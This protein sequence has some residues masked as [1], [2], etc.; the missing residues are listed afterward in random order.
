[1]ATN[2][3]AQ[4][5][6]KGPLSSALGQW[7]ALGIGSYY[8]AF[9][10]S[11]GSS[12]DGNHHNV[13]SLAA[14]E[15]AGVAYR[16]L[17][18][19]TREAAL[20][21]E[22]AALAGRL[23]YGQGPQPQP[24]V[25]YQQSSGSRGGYWIATIVQVGLGA[26]A[27]WTAYVI[28]SNFLPDTI[29]EMMPVTRKYFETA[30]TSLGQ[31]I[32]RVRE[33]LTE[34]MVALG[35]QQD[36]LADKQSEIHV[37]V[38]GLRSD[39]VD[40]RRHV[41]DIASAISR[42]EGSLTDA[43][44]RQNYM[45]KGVRLLVQCVG[46]LLRPGNPKVAE[47]LDR[48]SLLSSSEML[49]DDDMFYHPN[50]DDDTTHHRARCPSL[51]EIGSETTSSLVDHHDYGSSR[52]GAGRSSSLPPSPS[53]RSSSRPLDGG[54]AS[55][56]NSEDDQIRQ[57]ARSLLGANPAPPTMLPSSVTPTTS[58]VLKMLQSFNGGGGGGVGGGE[59]YATHKTS[60]AQSYSSPEDEVP[61]CS[62]QSTP[63]VV[64]NANHPIKLE[65]VDELL[66]IVRMM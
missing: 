54:R 4:L 46:D 7:I 39:L 45:S 14:N 38:L 55:Y 13:L 2:A 28:L 60:L 8:I 33:T 47:E 21:R 65:D 16:I 23:Q 29:K 34:Q 50:D 66:R 41:D 43:A 27:C 24:V 10:S 61:Q 64:G 26:T 36:Q 9:S 1:M 62:G 3:G 59:G 6:S 40:V 32:L 44:A 42:C 20:L 17:T 48:F 37:D 63:T 52:G 18:G 19:V 57:R 49:E 58:R 5:L 22:E 35:I 25:I 31:G 12:G 56:T 11:A 51:S 15:I 30:V 53:H